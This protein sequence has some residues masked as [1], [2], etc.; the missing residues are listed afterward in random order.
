MNSTIPAYRAI[1]NRLI[2]QAAQTE[3]AR[4]L[5]F[6]RPADTS[7]PKQ[8]AQFK[9]MLKLRRMRAERNNRQAHRPGGA[10]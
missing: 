4:R 10:A 8:W 2:E 3:E 7:D 5:R 9:V 1:S 6:W